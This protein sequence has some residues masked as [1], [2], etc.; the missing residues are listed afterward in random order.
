MNVK[1]IAEMGKSAIVEY[2][3]GATR[4]CIVPSE[5]VRGGAVMNSD[6]AAGIPY[7]VAWQIVTTEA[8]ADELRRVGIWTGMDL[9]ERPQVAAAAI[10]RVIG[11][12]LAALRKAAQNEGGTQ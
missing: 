7:G 1:V 8:V 3:D 9:A 4:R 12:T 10:Q 6:L 11:I 5:A 2:Y